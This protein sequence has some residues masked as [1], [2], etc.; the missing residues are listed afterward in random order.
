M[1]VSPFMMIPKFQT[2][3]Q[4]QELYLEHFGDFSIRNGPL[5]TNKEREST[6]VEVEKTD[7]GERSTLVAAPILFQTKGTKTAACPFNYSSAFVKQMHETA[8]AD[9]CEQSIYACEDKASM[10]ESIS[11]CTSQ[12]NQTEMHF[13]L[14]PSDFAGKTGYA[15]FLA[16]IADN[17]FV[18]RQLQNGSTA[19]G[20]GILF[21]CAPMPVM[22]MTSSMLAM[23]T[24][25]NNQ[26]GTDIMMFQPS[27]P[28]T[29]SSIAQPRWRRLS[30]CSSHLALA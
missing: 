29:I 12:G 18:F 16:S 10:V 21:H 1:L 9:K 24:Y 6:R 3:K 8:M 19:G 26:H 2:P 11:T 28:Q 22:T 5:I 27:C 7:Y 25:S 13:G 20:K 23:I 15:D 30:L 17:P 4:L 14:M